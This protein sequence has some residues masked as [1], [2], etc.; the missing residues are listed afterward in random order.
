MW[1]IPFHFFTQNLLVSHCLRRNWHFRTLHPRNWAAIVI[2]TILWMCRSARF[3]NKYKTIFWSCFGAGLLACVL[4]VEWF[5]QAPSEE[6]PVS[7]SKESSL[8][9]HRQHSDGTYSLSS[10]LHLR[11]DKNPPGTVITCRVSHPALETL[12][13]AT[14]TVGKPDPSKIY[15]YI[16]FTNM[17]Y[18]N[19]LLSMKLVNEKKSTF[20]MQSNWI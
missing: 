19:S 9:S 10:H 14:L 13:D 11:P 7:L 3:Q 6:E 2:A 12:S 17:I 1:N 8:S 5:S 16:F 18:V 20:H 4:Q 15:I